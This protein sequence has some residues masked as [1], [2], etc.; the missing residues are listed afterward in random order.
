[1]KLS[2][3]LAKIF[4]K[5]MDAV[6]EQEIDE[7]AFLAQEAFADCESRAMIMMAIATRKVV[8]T[9]GL[10]ICSHREEKHGEDHSEEIE[11]LKEHLSVD[12]R[13]VGTDAWWLN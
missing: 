12:E 13:E 5:E 7:P 1:M 4:E 11:S 8:K 6:I 3:E 10:A 2:H 9:L